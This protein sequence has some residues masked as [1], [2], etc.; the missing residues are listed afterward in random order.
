MRR[1][2][3][4]QLCS[5]IKSR[6]CSFTF[7]LYMGIRDIINKSKGKI[8][9]ARI[10]KEAKSYKRFKEYE[11]KTGR[12]L[13][14]D[15]ERT[16]QAEQRGYGSKLSPQ[17][18]KRYEKYNR[19]H[20]LRHRAGRIASG[21][22]EGISKGSKRFGIL[23]MNTSGR[24]TATDNDNTYNLGGSLFD[25]SDVV[26]KPTKKAQTSRSFL[27]GG[28]GGSLLFGPE[29]KRKKSNNGGLEN[30]FGA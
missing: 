27:D 26:S 21:F 5:S 4:I 23:D 6:P 12:K 7:I 19:E 13:R 11:Q 9:E 24:P 29:T 1:T 8:N 10:N 16:E 14:A 28:I 25:G 3:P 30:M 22:N 20:S 18:R 2:Y 15:R 17:D